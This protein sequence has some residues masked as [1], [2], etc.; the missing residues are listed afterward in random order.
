MKEVVIFDLD[1]CILDTRA[2]PREVTAP[3]VEGVDMLD[4]EPRRRECFKEALW[5]LSFTAA[6]EACG[7]SEEVA[8]QVYEAYARA[9]VPQGTRLSS[10]GDLE[11]LRRLPMRKFLVTSGF[12]RLQLSKVRALGVEEVF[13]DILVD[14]VQTKH[15]KGS[16]APAFEHV[17]AKAQARPEHVAV[18]G[19]SGVSELLVGKRMGMLT[20]Q[21]LRPHVKWW[22]HAD[23]H[24]SSFAELEDILCAQ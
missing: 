14:V 22:P 5:S 19:D 1:N 20:I 10:Y 15:K 3:L 9:E 12:E 11:Y 4:I 24:I 16:K 21:T 18:V 6:V 17:L 2:M 23:H 13:E 7:I 8:R